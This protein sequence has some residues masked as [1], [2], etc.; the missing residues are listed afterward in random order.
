MIIEKWTQKESVFKRQDAYA[1]TPLTIKT[2][3]V[4]SK[5]IMLDGKEFYLSVASENLEKL[6]L[7]IGETPVL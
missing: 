5:V 6:N 1:F 4:L 2:C 3:G 7:S